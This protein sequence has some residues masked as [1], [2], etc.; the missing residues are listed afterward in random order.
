MSSYLILIAFITFLSNLFFLKLIIPVFKKYIFDIPVIRSSHSVIKPTG[1]GIVFT[2]SSIMGNL[3]LG[4]SNFLLALPLAIVGLIDDCIKI[5][6][7]IRFIFQLFTV[8][9]IL[10]NS[11]NVSIMLNK[12]NENTLLKYFVFLIFLII[13]SGIINFVNF[14]DGIDGLVAGCMVIIFTTIS[15]VIDNSFLIIAISLLAFLFFN[16]DPAKIFMGDV[17]ST[18][19]GSIYVLA[20]T[21]CSKF[22]EF[23]GILI[24]ASPL[25]LDS[26]TCLLYRF[27]K[28]QNIFKPHKLHLY[29]RLNQAG[30][31]HQKVSIIYM[32]YTLVLSITYLNL[33]IQYLYFLLIFEVFLGIYLNK[34]FA[35]SFVNDKI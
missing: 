8:S 11:E 16:W 17:G 33:E 29:Q 14:M 22:D 34:N 13:A 27:F 32:A 23:V 1:G 4:N 2:V 3:L 12:L 21:K 31:S 9:F 7:K 20:L 24:L 28:G 5:S 10:S 6:S 19:I 35:Q 26:L 30:F 15:L 25:L 18:F